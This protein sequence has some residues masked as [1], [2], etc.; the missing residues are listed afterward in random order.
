MPARRRSWRAAPRRETYGAALVRNLNFA[1][2][3]TTPFASD[4]YGRRLIALKAG[5]H[6]GNWRD[7]EDR[8]WRRP[9]PLRRERRVAAPAALEA[10]ARLHESSLLKPFLDQ[11]AEERL[12][13]AAAMAQVWRREAPRLF[14]VTVTAEAARLEA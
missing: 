9:L 2:A 4:P 12:S 10:I 11:G 13:N 7:S 1:V 8:A 14:D 6:V 3:T 5:E